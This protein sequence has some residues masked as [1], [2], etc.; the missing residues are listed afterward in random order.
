[1][2]DFPLGCFYD[3]RSQNS[4]LLQ[5]APQGNFCVHWEWNEGV[6]WGAQM[7]SLDL[8]DERIDLHICKNFSSSTL[9]INVL[10]CLQITP[11]VKRTKECIMDFSLPQ[12][13]WGWVGIFSPC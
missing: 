6:L 9:K 11:Q 7:S 2:A 5:E 12:E 3:D 4:V 8:G 10:N 13:Y 1:M